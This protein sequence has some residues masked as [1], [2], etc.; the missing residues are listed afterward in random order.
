MATQD[1]FVEP[2][3][4]KQFRRYYRYIEP[5]VSDPIVRSYFSI[6][7]SLI[8]VAVFV[9]FALSPT[10]TTIL[11]LVKKIDDQKKTISS[12]DQKIDALISAQ[13]SYSSF[14]PNLPALLSALP[15]TSTPETVID[16][17]YTA[18]STSAVTVSALQFGEIPVSTDSGR[19]NKDTDSI[20]KKTTASSVDISLVVTGDSAKIEAFLEKVEQM[21]RI[22]RIT[23]L[24]F[25]SKK[26][27]VTISAKSYFLPRKF[28]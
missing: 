17:V 6:V 5:V 4:Y 7:A 19:V 26:G 23:N 9:I 16:A 18:A 25:G 21:S 20:A 10:L 13:D 27:I 14:Q 3:F 22:I 15:E 8:L 28:P 1:P 12:M 11:G 24:S 2:N